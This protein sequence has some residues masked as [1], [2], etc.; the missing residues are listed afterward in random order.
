MSLG[1]CPKCQEDRCE[2]GYEYKDF[3][4]RNVT[5]FILGILKEYK[6]KE[7]DQILF[8]IEEG[9]DELPK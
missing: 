7:R 2:C 4:V 3:G 5:D 6:Q 9:L 8:L 1:S